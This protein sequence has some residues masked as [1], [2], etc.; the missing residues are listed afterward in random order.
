MAAHWQEAI[1]K[2]ESLGYSITLNS[3]KLNYVYHGE[4]IPDP[5]RVI[6]L[7]EAIKTHKGQVVE[8]L[9]K[10]AC[11]E[12]EAMFNQ[13]LEEINSKYVFGTIP[14]IKGTHPHLWQRLVEVENKLSEAWLRGIDDE[15]KRN[16]DE[17]TNLNFKAIEAFKGRDI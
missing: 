9:K 12:F 10:Q 14:Y 11:I 13:A 2:L 1:A 4:G 16:L 3:G 15:F 17:W 5:A 7:L 6:P 8:H